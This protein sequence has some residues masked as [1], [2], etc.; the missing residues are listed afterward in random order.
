MHHSIRYALLGVLTILLSACASTPQKPT[1]LPNT[2]V[3]KLQN[4][5][6][7]SRLPIPVKGVS[8]S[9]LS[10]TWGAARSQGRRH[11][12][13]DIMAARGTKVYS[14]TDGLVADLRNNN[15]GGKVV[16]ILGPSG[17][18]HYYAHLDR[19]KRG[20]NVGDYVRKGEH[21]GYVGNTGNARHTAP[22]LHYGIYLN[23]KGRGAVNPFPYLR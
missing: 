7:D 6:L 8:R 10:D 13:I 9:A 1:P 19:H 5:H 20:L 3:N 21:I 15:L 4:M 2:Q 17:S 16:W 12:G 11:E 14:A 23:G 22:H 18:W